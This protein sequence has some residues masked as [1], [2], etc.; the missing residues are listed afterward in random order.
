MNE[1]LVACPAC[2]T[3]FKVTL[4]VLRMAD[5]WC[6]CGYCTTPFDAQ[7]GLMI[8]PPDHTLH[9]IQQ[10]LNTDAK[11][12]VLTAVFSVIGS[13]NQKDTETPL[14]SSLSD[15]SETLHPS[16]TA[17]TADS[18]STASSDTET[19]VN[20]STAIPNPTN[21]A[22]V[23][24]HV[25]SDAITHES[26]TQTEKQLSDDRVPA[27]K[28]PSGDVSQSTRDAT[29]VEKSVTASSTNTYK[30]SHT[31]SDQVAKHLFGAGQEIL[32]EQNAWEKRQKMK[33]NLM[34]WIN[35]LAAIGILAAIAF[36]SQAISQQWPATATLFQALGLPTTP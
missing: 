22:G 32:S 15:A 27:S 34:R 13:E 20:P 11:L 31:P 2:Q 18:L 5:G 12:P 10:H 29:S 16:T 24:T 17:L 14:E 7:M 30:S 35:V 28:I 21:H 3:P 25:L 23:E 4:D 26:T 8:L 36:N 6:T 1:F 9:F 19:H 33:S